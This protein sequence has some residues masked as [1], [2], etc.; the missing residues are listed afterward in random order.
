MEGDRSCGRLRWP[1]RPRLRSGASAGAAI[2]ARIGVMIVGTGAR[3]AGTAARASRVHSPRRLRVAAAIQRPP[4]ERLPRWPRSLRLDPARRRRAGNP[5]GHRPRAG[6]S[7]RGRADDAVAIAIP[8]DGL[9]PRGPSSR[10]DDRCRCALPASEAATVINLPH[11]LLHPGNTGHKVG[12]ALA[13]AG[14]RRR[15]P[16]RGPGESRKSATCAHRVLAAF[17]LAP[18]SKQ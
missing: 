18:G 9:L 1:A 12:P 3:I 7:N 6:A 15:S 14:T 13:P 10:L 5:A 4:R 17:V 8:V 2:G 11:A 16:A